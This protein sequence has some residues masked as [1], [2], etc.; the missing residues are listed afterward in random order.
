MPR[1]LIAKGL[2]RSFDGKEQG[3]TTVLVKLETGS[4]PGAGVPGFDGVVEPAGGAHDG[5]GS[6]F[7]TVNLVQTARLV[8]RGHQ[9]HVGARLDFVR[10]HIVVRDLDRDLLGKL[11][12]QAQEHFFVILVAGT[13]HG[14][15]HVL[16]CQPI[17]DLRNQVESLLGGKTRDDADD[18]EFGIGILDSERGHQ[19]GLVLRLL[20]KVQRR[21]PPGNERIVGWIPDIVIDPIQ[22]AGN[23]GC[24]VPQDAFQAETVLGR[25]D[26]LAVLLA[27]GGDVVGEHEGAFEKVDLSE[28]FHL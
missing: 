25:L 11:F 23:R 13:Q 4:L 20:G 15:N 14:Q 16:A 28:E 27:H 6:V 18:G 24:P 26:F 12:L 7:Q 1:S 3:L 17:H 21:I 5:H 10:D 22:D 9:E 8:A 2:Q 19:V